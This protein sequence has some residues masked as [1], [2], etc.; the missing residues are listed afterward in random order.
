MKDGLTEEEAKERELAR[1][2]LMNDR[3]REMCASVHFSQSEKDPNVI[4]VM[5]VRFSGFRGI[6]DLTT[7]AYS[8]WKVNK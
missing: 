6:F 3:W 8:W 7:E 4:T 2:L 5:N 1:I